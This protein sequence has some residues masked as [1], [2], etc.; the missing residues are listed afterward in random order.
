MAPRALGA[1][2]RGS[3]THSPFLPLGESCHQINSLHCAQ[4]AILVFF[5][6]L[7]RGIYESVK[8]GGQKGF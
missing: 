1:D 3:S 7:S 6:R 2:I 5:H 4:E 8:A